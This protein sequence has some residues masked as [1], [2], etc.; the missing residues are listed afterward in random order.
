MKNILSNLMIPVGITPVDDQNQPAPVDPNVPIEFACLDAASFS[1]GI[2]VAG[3]RIVGSAEA[4]NLFANHGIK[5]DGTMGL[6]YPDDGAVVA[7]FFVVARADADVG[8]GVKTIEAASEEC[9]IVMPE[10]TNLNF[11]F[12]AAIPKEP[13]S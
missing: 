10:A 1:T 13:L 6:L 11:G 4:P 3:V 5:T 12:G 2:A 7:S 8:A 9:A